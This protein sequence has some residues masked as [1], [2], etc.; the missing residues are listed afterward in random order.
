SSG[1]GTTCTGWSLTARCRPSPRSWPPTPARST[2]T[3]GSPSTTC[4][5]SRA[6]ERGRPVGF[7]GLPA[8]GREGLLP[9]RIRSVHMRPAEPDADRRTPPG[10]VAF[11]G[12]DRA[13]ETAH[14]RVLQPTTGLLGGPPDA[15]DP[16]RWAVEPDSQALDVAFRRPKHIEETIAVEVSLSIER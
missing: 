5:R 2:T 9:L 7:P 13:V 14:H 11:E 16:F 15:P 1:T 12:A 4:R 3:A 8:V 6:G 10:V